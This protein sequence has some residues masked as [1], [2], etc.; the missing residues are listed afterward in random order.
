M[1]YLAE[2]PHFD[3]GNDRSII[4]SHGEHRMAPSRMLEG[5]LDDADGRRAVLSMIDKTN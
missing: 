4:R 5:Y 1:N 2:I 3:D